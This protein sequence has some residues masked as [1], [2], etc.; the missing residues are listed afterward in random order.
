MVFL[1]FHRK[2]LFEA[3][4]VLGKIFVFINSKNGVMMQKITDFRTITLDKYYKNVLRKL[5]STNLSV[6]KR[7]LHNC[8]IGARNSLYPIINHE[9]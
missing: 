7:K 8:V 3:M 2:S 6:Y 9:P 1:F 4:V 5:G